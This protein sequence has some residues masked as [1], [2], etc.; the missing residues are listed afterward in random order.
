MKIKSFDI[1]DTLLAR[2][3][4]SRDNLGGVLGS[5]VQEH[6][7]D[8][9]S[10]AIAQNFETIRR[11]ANH[12]AHTRSEHPEIRLEEIYAAIAARYP[13]IDKETLERIQKFEE[14]LE[15][16][17]CYGITENIDRALHFLDAKERVILISDMYHSEATIRRMLE[18][19]EPRLATLPLYLSSECRLRKADGDLYSYVI[20]KEGVSPDAIE[21]LGDNLHSDYTMAK[22]M[23]LSTSLYSTSHNNQIEAAYLNEKTGITACVYTGVSRQVRLK[24][25]YTDRPASHTL[26]A[27]YSAPLFFGFVQWCLERAA[28]AGIQDIY[29]LARDGHI[30]IEIA[31]RLQP[32]I[33]PD[34]R[35]HYLYISRQ[36]TFLASISRVT[37]QS[38]NWVFEEMDNIITLERA[39]KRLHYN[40]E[41]LEALLPPQD[42]PSRTERLSSNQIRT[43]RAAILNDVSIRERI[44]ASA[45]E[46]RLALKGYLKQCGIDGSST[47]ALVDIGWKASIQDCI[48]RALSA[49]QPTLQIEGFYYGCSHFSSATSSKNQK[50]PYQITP[51]N[52]P[53]LGPILELLLMAPHGTTMGYRKDDSGNYIPEL[54]DYNQTKSN[55]DM[56]AYFDGI[57]QFTELLLEVKDAHPKVELYPSAVDQI[58]LE[59]LEDPPRILAE[60]LG[61]LPYCGDQEESHPR[62]MA[63]AFSV[64]DAL[65][66]LITSQSSRTQMTQW[67]Q[68][69]FKRSALIPRAILAL[70][71]RK[72]IF[73]F[74]RDLASDEAHLQKL[75]KIRKMLRI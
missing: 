61:D 19:I 41:D 38:L 68:A 40:C 63:P 42:R 15:V 62:A 58:L 66:Y 25:P 52:L 22:R 23:G 67:F 36:S 69:S 3:L 57:T 14:D 21:H 17:L 34:T 51:S 30:L 75:R 71:P 31:R 73:K 27:A 7:S 4:N 18:K 16:E 12:H 50:H 1:F 6:F 13:E 48:Y 11:E 9:L 74:A 65:K 29:F 54:K 37:D 35:L 56:Q 64:F 60:G 24:Q 59:L 5:R 20:D 10:I 70:D 45:R 44:E 49:D 2:S 33:A 53:G 32:R 55:W 28:A 47:V 43:I 72:A 26:G 39:A 46:A 8:Q